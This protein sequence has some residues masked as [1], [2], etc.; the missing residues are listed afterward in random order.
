M[1]SLQYQYFIV[2]DTTHPARYIHLYQVLEFI[3][4]NCF[5]AAGKTFNSKHNA[6]S[7]NTLLH[8][9]W[10]IPDD[11]IQQKEGVVGGSECLGRNELSYYH[12]FP[13]DT[14]LL[15]LVNREKWSF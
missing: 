2:M 12:V 15:C 13:G 8:L 7:I 1:S 4:N 14:L 3:I 11:F 10:L 9:F 6:V 5:M